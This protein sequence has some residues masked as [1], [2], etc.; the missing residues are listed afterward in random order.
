M[1]QFDPGKLRYQAEFFDPPPADA[2]YGT[3]SSDQADYVLVYACRCEL[4][5]TE[6]REQLQ[7]GQTTAVLTHTVTIRSNHKPSPLQR[8]KIRDRLFEVVGVLANDGSLLAGDYSRVIA[9]E[10]QA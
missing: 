10:V 2:Q 6:A 1:S 7:L 3:R 5:P 4:R 8:I 9:R